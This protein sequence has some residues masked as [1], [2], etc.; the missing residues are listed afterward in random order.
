[1]I[2]HSTALESITMEVGGG[3]HHVSSSHHTTFPHETVGNLHGSSSDRQSGDSYDGVDGGGI[4][5]VWGGI[6]AK[7]HRG[8]NLLLF[9]GI[10]DILQSYGMLKKVEHYW[11][12][13]IHDGDTVS[14]HRPGF[15]AR[16]FQ[17]FMKEKVFRK[18][19]TNIKPTLSFRRSHEKKQ[20]S[21]SDAHLAGLDA[22]FSNSKEGPPVRGGGAKVSICKK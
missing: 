3:D 12:S 14:V 18:Q 19:V 22:S 5:N 9:I 1:M 8:E 15:Y 4:N 2:A 16:R 11:K 6:P 21:T 7:N 20:T 13:L 10:I 17:S